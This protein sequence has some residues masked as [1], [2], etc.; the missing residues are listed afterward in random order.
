MYTSKFFSLCARHDPSWWK[1]LKPS[2][3]LNCR[4]RGISFSIAKLA[5]T[6]F[7]R[8]N[9]CYRNIQLVDEC[10]ESTRASKRANVTSQ[11][12]KQQANPQP[13]KRVADKQ[14]SSR[15]ANEKQ[16]S[17]RAPARAGERTRASEFL[18]DKRTN[19]Q[20]GGPLGSHE[21]N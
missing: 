6:D 13:H 16:T 8:N 19:Q 5:I 3:R 17:E 12:A 15:R 20:T 9:D 14:T 11:Q 7:N 10:F 18:A 21:Q 1:C 4:S 2:W